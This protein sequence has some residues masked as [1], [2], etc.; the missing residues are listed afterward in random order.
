MTIR[1]YHGLEVV[2]KIEEAVGST[3][4]SRTAGRSVGP[5]N[6]SSKR[7]P[8]KPATCE[9]WRKA[10]TPRGER[11]EPIMPIFMKQGE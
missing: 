8:T 5:I 9:A 10:A 6:R 11:L 2:R 1:S 4:W 7:Q 3:I